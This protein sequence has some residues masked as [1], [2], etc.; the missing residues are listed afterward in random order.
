MRTKSGPMGPPACCGFQAMTP[1]AGEQGPQGSHLDL[2]SSELVG[3]SAFLA[4]F[5]RRR[6]PDGRHLS[7]PLYPPVT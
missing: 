4:A 5:C 6:Y 1:E 7:P 2:P 3:P